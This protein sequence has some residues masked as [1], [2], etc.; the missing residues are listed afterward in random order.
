[1][2]LLLIVFFSRVA[3]VS[4]GT[5][6]TI[7]TVRGNRTLAALI[8]FVEV[9]VWFLVAR[10]ALN[11]GDSSIYIA[12]SYAGGYAA[13]TYVGGVL[14]KWLFPSNCLVQVITSKRDPVLLKAIADEGYS[15]TVSD[16]YGRD[17]ISE[18]YMIFIHLK[19]KYVAKLQKIVIENDPQAFISI[20]EGR[21]SINGSIVP[22]FNSK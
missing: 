18:K 16:V 4:L 8:G 11:S 21:N 12:I 17:H 6:R 7:M 2:I 14:A 20:S 5:I 13:G 3:D 22:Y 1:M 19:G 10:E 9:L 15:M